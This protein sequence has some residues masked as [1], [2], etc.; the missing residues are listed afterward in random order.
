[1]IN[2]EIETIT[3]EM[4]AQMLEYNPRNRRLKDRHV[5]ELAGAMER[6]EW[7]LNGE[8]IKLSGKNVIDGQHRLWA[9]LRANKPFKTLLVRGLPMNAQKTVDTGKIRT[10]PDHL[11]MLGESYAGLLANV[12]YR[13]YHYQK[14]SL[15]ERRSMTHKQT[16]KFL[17]ENPTLRDYVAIYGSLR[18]VGPKA[19]LASAHFIFAEIDQAQADDFMERYTKGTGLEEGSPILTLR[20]RLIKDLSSETKL[21]QFQKFAMFIKA[22]NTWRDGEQMHRIGYRPTEDFP[23]AR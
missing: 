13:V 16:E 3:P 1:M 4:A 14:G 9:C 10:N 11:Q 5:A 19:L 20:N 17:M 23:V 2:Y 18:P 15:L 7:Q 12:I 8:S 22:W 21:N 6:G